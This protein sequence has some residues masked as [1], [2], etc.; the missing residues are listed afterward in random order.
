M[1]RMDG[2]IDEGRAYGPFP[3]APSHPVQSAS[4]RLRVWNRRLAFK[5]VERGIWFWDVVAGGCFDLVDSPRS[6][7]R[8]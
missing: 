6:R 1:L 7:G 2:S 5:G 3:V 4:A 8:G